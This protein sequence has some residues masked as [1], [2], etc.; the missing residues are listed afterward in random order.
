MGECPPSGFW[1]FFY[2]LNLEKKIFYN[3]KKGSWEKLPPSSGFRTKFFLWWAQDHDDGEPSSQKSRWRRALFSKITMTESPF[4]KKSRRR[5]ALFSKITM[6]E[7]PFLKK[8]RWRRALFSKI[9]RLVK[10]KIW[11]SSIHF[12]GSKN[13]VCPSPVVKSWL[14]ACVLH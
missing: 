9:E 2:M 6:T 1:D 11:S 7:S 10:K 4:L 12:F 8:S 5:R 13:F 3:V 14:R